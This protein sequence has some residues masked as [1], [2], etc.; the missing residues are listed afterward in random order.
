MKINV[1]FQKDGLH[2]DRV[3]AIV[4]AVGALYAIKDLFYGAKQHGPKKEL[5]SKLNLSVT[6]CNNEHEVFDG[7]Y[8][9][10]HFDNC[11]VKV[12]VRDV[13]ELDCYKHTRYEN[14]HNRFS[15]NS[16]WEIYKILEGWLKSV[17]Y[18]L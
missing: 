13:V 18:T 2:A 4:T 16:Y 15:A 17:N 5:V 3:V 11:T 7:E 8:F 9:D 14:T 12:S 10:V 6:C 1:N